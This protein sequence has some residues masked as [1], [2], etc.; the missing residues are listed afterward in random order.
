MTHG[1]I[2]CSCGELIAQCRC[3]SQ[4]GHV[5]T[6]RVNGCEKCQ[7]KKLHGFTLNAAGQPTHIDGVKLEESSV[8]PASFSRPP[9]LHATADPEARF[10]KD[11]GPIGYNAP[12]KGR[13]CE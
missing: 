2:V 10:E 8:A 13:A 4:H 7:E 12:Q 1:K 3:I 5:E 9:G 11:W 6:T